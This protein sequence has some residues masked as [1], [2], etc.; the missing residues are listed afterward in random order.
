M[1][2]ILVIDDEVQIRTMLRQQLERAS[3]DVAVAPD[4][5]VGMEL[6]REEPAD[7]VIV[8]LLM[9]SKDGIET[10]KEL[11]R[12]FPEVRII[13]MSGGG[14]IGPEAYLD[15]AKKLG[16]K[17]T[18]KKPIERQELLEAVRELLE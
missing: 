12:E 14:H 11:T 8:D 16:A 3:Y 5:K 18:L 17:R 4:G 1:E 9:P 13:A 10:I 7:L 6:H 2:R 15:M